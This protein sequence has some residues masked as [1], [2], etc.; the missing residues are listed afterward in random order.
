[1]SFLQDKIYPLLP[2]ALQNVAISMAGY[3][4]H[5]RRFGGV[6]EAQVKEFKDRDGYTTEQWQEY[7]TVELRKLLIHA[8]ETVPYY[9]ELFKKEGFTKESFST[10]ELSDLPKLPFLD[11]NTYRQI[12]TTTLLSTI[13]EPDGIF[14]PSSGST[15]TPT[16]T[17]TS[18]INHQR[19]TAGNEAR[20]RNWAGVTQNDP[21]GM[22][23]GR[24]I[25]PGGNPKPPF[26]RYN[27]VEKQVYLS[28]Y[29]ISKSTAP[30]YLE[31]LKKY[32]AT[33]MNG[34]AASNFVLAR[35]F[36]ELGLDAPQMKAVI[37]SSEK[38]TQEM[39]DTYQKVY[40]CKTYDAYSS[41]EACCLISECEHGKLHVS[42]D[43]GIIE[44]LNDD[45]EPA[46]AGEMAEMVCTGIL[47]YNQPLIRYRMKDLAVLSDEKC[48]CGREMQVVKE[49]VGRIEDLVIGRDG[50]EF[51][52]F[53]NVFVN[54][55]NIIEGQVVQNDY[56]DFELNVASQN[57][58]SEAEKE[59]M[60]KRMES[61]LGEIN[62]K[63]NEVASIPRTKNGKFKT[64]VSKV[65]RK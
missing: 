52:Y 32:G 59:T 15:G 9:R 41:V 54:L 19:V 6:F 37:S 13:Q 18:A 51:A 28:P 12:G 24:R 35:F 46:K 44:F 16:K 17:M 50:R 27:L 5:K 36:D 4:W 65:K 31:G 60:I 56:E 8:I 23:G 63:I 1:M 53:Y 43:M 22:I 34:Y 10:F 55:P 38:L 3:K 33:Y 11:K 40:G 25:V 57:G 62:V 2:V 61:Q 48:A 29:H 42:P 30:N 49:I 58:L 64:V 7:Q 14:L 47:N 21:R 39:R 20:I 26:Y 45:G